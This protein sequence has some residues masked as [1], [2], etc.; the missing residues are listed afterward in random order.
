MKM[1]INYEKKIFRYG[2]LDSLRGFVLVSMIPIMDAGIWS[3]FLGRIGIGI[4]GQA[5]TFGSRVSVGVLFCFPVFAGLW[6]N[7]L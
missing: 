1:D 7:I 5:H 3:I 6:V 4:Q 2:L